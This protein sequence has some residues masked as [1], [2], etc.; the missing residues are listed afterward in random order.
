[1]RNTLLL[2]PRDVTV[3][4]G[5]RHNVGATADVTIAIKNIPNPN[6]VNM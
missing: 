6:I 1:M 5:C 4:C 3:P 2:F